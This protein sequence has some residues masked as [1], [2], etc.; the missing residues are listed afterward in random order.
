LT[1]KA[2][3]KA[4]NLTFKAKAKDLTLKAKGKDLPHEEVQGLLSIRVF[5][6]AKFNSNFN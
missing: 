2:T 5:M 4:K 3:A 1:F 6:N